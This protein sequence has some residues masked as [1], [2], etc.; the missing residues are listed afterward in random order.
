MLLLHY[1]FILDNEYV[2]PDESVVTD[3]NEWAD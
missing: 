1:D 3:V 2:L